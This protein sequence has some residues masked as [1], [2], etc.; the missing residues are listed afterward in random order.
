ME[1]QATNNGKGDGG[2]LEGFDVINTFGDTR[3]WSGETN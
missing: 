2:R 3:N 1:I